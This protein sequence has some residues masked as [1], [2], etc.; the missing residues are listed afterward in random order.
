MYLQSVQIKLVI[1]ECKIISYKSVQFQ[2]KII[3]IYM[4]RL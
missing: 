4:Q 2:T 3:Y 1:T